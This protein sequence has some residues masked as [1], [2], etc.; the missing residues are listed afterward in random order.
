MIF[1]IEMN[2]NDLPNDVFYN[3]CKHLSFTDVLNLSKTCKQFYI[4]IEHEVYFWMVLIQN[5]FGSKLY[6]RYVNEILQNKKNSNYVLYRM[7]KD[8]KNIF[9]GIWSRKCLMFGY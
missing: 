9:E 6:R 4:L 3:I 2:L 8:L 7:E 5:H 1:Q